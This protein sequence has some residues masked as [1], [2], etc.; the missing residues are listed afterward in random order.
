MNIMKQFFG[1]LQMFPEILHID[2]ILPHI[3]GKKEFYVFDKGEYS[4]INY[5]MT[6]SRTFED[7]NGNLNPYLLECRGSKFCNKTGKILARPFHKFFN[8]GENKHSHIEHFE[9]LGY[10]IL[11]KLDGSFIHPIFINDSMRLCTK[12]GITDIS[13]MAESFIS[14]KKKYL[15]FIHDCEKCG[16]TPIFEYISKSNQVIIEY[17]EENLVLLAIRDKISGKYQWE[18]M[19][20]NYGVPKVQQVYTHHSLSDFIENHK[21][22]KEIEGHVISF[23]NGQRL[24]IKTPWYIERHKA[25]DLINQEHDTVLLIV[26]NEIDDI[27]NSS[28]VSET[29][30]E[31]IEKLET[32]IKDFMINEVK[33]LDDLVHTIKE[34]YNFDRKSIGL[35]QDIDQEDKA[36]LFTYLKNDDIVDYITNKLIKICSKKSDYENWKNKL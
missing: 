35:S 10:H 27:K 18:A 13:M 17:N 4:V 12:A 24:K 23:F 30:I 2:D 33:R 25:K 6:D 8:I 19:A 31:R 34:K 21:D 15:D 20:D 28:F 26:K 11:E 16:F 1:T 14:D 9:G 36:F 5:V 3:E 22:M 7:E 32:F 29:D